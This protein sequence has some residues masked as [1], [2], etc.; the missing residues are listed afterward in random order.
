AGHFNAGFTGDFGGSFGSRG[1]G[2]VGPL[3]LL[4][5]IE[6]HVLNISGRRAV[7]AVEPNEDAGMIAEAGDL[8]DERGGGDFFGFGSP[9]VPVLPGVAA[10]PAGHDED[11]EFVG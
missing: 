5:N 4:Q 9:L 11:A 8:V 7:A 3:E 2:W 10:D 1:D 6:V